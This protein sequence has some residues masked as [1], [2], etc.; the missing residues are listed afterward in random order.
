MATTDRTNFARDLT[1]GSYPYYCEPHRA[2][3]MV[4]KIIV[5]G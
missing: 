4:G 1:P 2:A 3:G 5:K